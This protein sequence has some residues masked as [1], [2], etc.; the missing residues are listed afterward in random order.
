MLLH[1]PGIDVNKANKDEATPLWLASAA[2]HV[3]VV[4]LLLDAPGI[5]VNKAS[6]GDHYRPWRYS[7]SHTPLHAAS[8]GGHLEVVKALLQGPG[9]DVNRE[10]EKGK[11]PLRVASDE[12]QIEVVRALLGAPGIDV[13]LA[14][15]D[16]ATP[17]HAVSGLARADMVEVLLQAPGIRALQENDQGETALDCVGGNYDRHIYSDRDAHERGY[18]LA[19]AETSSL[20]WEAEAVDTKRTYC[21]VL[22][23]LIL[24]GVPRSEAA[25]LAFL[26]L[27]T[28]RAR[29]LSTRMRDAWLSSSQSHAPPAK[30]PRA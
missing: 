13:N 26:C 18:W 24:G 4:R 9:I 22:L 25:S 6:K 11:T 2:G 16:G 21:R 15:K 23:A 17:L 19:V 7:A 27:P 1:E 20:L 8:E 30:R 28:K 10:D 29:A 14:G 5:D 12:G 3:A